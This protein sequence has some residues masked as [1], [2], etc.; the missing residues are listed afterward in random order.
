MNCYFTMDQSP[1][2][3]LSS[4]ILDNNSSFFFSN[5]LFFAVYACFS[6]SYIYNIIYTLMEACA[7]STKPK[8]KCWL[9][10]KSTTYLPWCKVTLPFYT[11]SYPFQNMQFPKLRC[12]RSIP[13][14]HMTIKTQ[15]RVYILS[16]SS[17]FSLYTLSL[18]I[19]YN[20]FGI[21]HYVHCKRCY[22]IGWWFTRMRQHIMK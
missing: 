1:Q 21:G 3:L 4:A 6:N 2:T 8:S 9:D 14:C 11:K 15:V 10:Y 22:A 12:D 18:I 16:Y 20:L 13:S 5:A 19:V 17:L 7:V